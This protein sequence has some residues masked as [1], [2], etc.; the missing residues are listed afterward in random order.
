MHHRA[1]FL[2]TFVALTALAPPA[3]AFDPFEIQVY[4]GESNEPGT[5]GLELHV[6]Y[7][8]AHRRPFVAPELSQDRLAHYTFEPALGITRSW[9]I[10]AYVQFASQGDALFW[11]G[12]KLRSKWVTPDGWHP[13]LHLGLNL[14][15]AFIP[16]RFDADGV[17]GEL[18]PIVAWEDTYV[19]LAFNPN[20]EFALAGAGLREGPELTPAFAAY[21]RVPGAVELGVEYY[22]SMGPIADLPDFSQQEHYVFAAGNVL[23]FAG[24]EVN[25]GVGVGLTPASNDVIAKVILGHAIG[26]LWGGTS[27]PDGLAGPASAT[28]PRPSA[29]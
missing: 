14:E 28:N 13:H 16:Q 21:V 5:A 11:G 20:V 6:N 3:L 8:R 18:R 15:I 17:G 1:A 2:G 7:N 9:E 25:F 26:R 22:A 12:A 29:R 4:D 27:L 10:G 19:H 23:A 24:W